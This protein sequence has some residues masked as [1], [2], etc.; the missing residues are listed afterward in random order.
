MEWFIETFSVQNKSVF[1]IGQWNSSKRIDGMHFYGDTGKV[2]NINGEKI[3]YSI[4]TDR[5]MENKIFFNSLAEAI[6]IYGKYLS[7]VKLHP[8]HF[9]NAK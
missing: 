9:N 5:N 7:E 2:L 4:S 6:A 3:Q 8:I 1:C